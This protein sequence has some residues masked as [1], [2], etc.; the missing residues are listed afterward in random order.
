M[1]IPRDLLGENL[2]KGKPPQP[3]QHK[4]LPFSA[5][6]DLSSPRPSAEASAVEQG[7]NGDAN[8]LLTNYTHLSVASSSHSRGI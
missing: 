8:L 3:Q 7:Q 6:A 2:G 1:N 5:R 4:V